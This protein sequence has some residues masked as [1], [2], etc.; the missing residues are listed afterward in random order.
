LAVAKDRRPRRLDAASTQERVSRAASVPQP[1]T[2]HTLD[3]AISLGTYRGARITT[4]RRQPAIARA[5]RRPVRGRRPYH[6]LRQAA[7]TKAARP[8]AGLAC[9]AKVAAPA[10]PGTCRRRACL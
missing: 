6:R 9:D 7:R 5:L 4:L 8:S 3:S 1:T 2:R 10:P